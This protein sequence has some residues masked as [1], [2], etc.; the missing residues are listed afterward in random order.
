MTKS[1]RRARLVTRVQPAAHTRQAR[2]RPLLRQEQHRLRS[3]RSTTVC[4]MQLLR[5]FR[6]RLYQC[7][8]A[9]SL[10]WRL[11]FGSLLPRLHPTSSSGGGQHIRHT[12]NE[13]ELQG[14]S[15][16]ANGTARV[17]VLFSRLMVVSSESHRLHTLL[18]E[19]LQ[20]LERYCFQVCTMC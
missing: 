5:K 13:R 19:P 16:S 14:I 6:P 7:S 4:F 17:A 20:R 11:V 9:A 12:S 18:P 15:E 2:G 1:T 10:T 8:F 3:L